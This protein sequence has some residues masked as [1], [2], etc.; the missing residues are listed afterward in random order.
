[1][2][3]LIIALFTVL[4]QAIMAARSNPVDALKYE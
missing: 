3:A 2:S 4:Y 1:L